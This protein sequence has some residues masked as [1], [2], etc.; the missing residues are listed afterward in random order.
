METKNNYRLKLEALTTQITAKLG[1]SGDRN[2]RSSIFDVVY[3]PNSQAMLSC[4]ETKISCCFRDLW[5]LSF[6]NDT[7][8]RKKRRFTQRGGD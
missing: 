1:L 7:E 8:H 6:L 5:H 3:R 4:I 2:A